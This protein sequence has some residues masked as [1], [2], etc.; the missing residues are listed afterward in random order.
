MGEWRIEELSADEV[1]QLNKDKAS[2]PSCQDD[3]P[4]GEQG[5][6]DDQPEEWD[7]TA[8]TVVADSNEGDQ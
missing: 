7:I 2:L 3:V 4:D 5:F 6:G 1:D 8:P